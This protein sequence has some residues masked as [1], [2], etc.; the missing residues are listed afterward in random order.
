MENDLKEINQLFFEKTKQAD[1]LDRQL[2]IINNE[3]QDFKIKFEQKQA[4]KNK[5]ELY[6]K[7]QV[8]NELEQVCRF[9]L[10]RT[11]RTYDCLF[12]FK[13]IENL[14]KELELT[15][16]LQLKYSEEKQ[17]NLE[18]E[19]NQTINLQQ[20]NEK[21]IQTINELNQKLEIQTNESDATIRVS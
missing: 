5:E 13:T 18:N 17:L 16:T 20:E 19:Q 14:K 12:Y 7:A 10:S 8:V 1:D 11:I 9:N 21:L 6:Q 3:Y 4:E 2:Q 15:K